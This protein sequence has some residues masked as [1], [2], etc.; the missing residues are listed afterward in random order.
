MS[1]KSNFNPGII[2]LSGVL[3]LGAVPSAFSQTSSQEKSTQPATTRSTTP[4]KQ[5]TQKDMGSKTDQMQK[6]MAASPDDIRKAQQA[7]KDKGMYDGAV[8]GTMNAQF[9]K[10]LTD[11][12]TQNK[13]QVTG[14]L[15]HQTMMKLGITPTK[16]TK[17]KKGNKQGAFQADPKVRQVQ[18]ALQ[19]RGI[20]PGPIDGIM[21]PQTKKAIADFQRLQ[22]LYVSGHLDPQTEAA[23]GI[24]TMQNKTG[25]ENKREKPAAPKP[26][27]TPYNQNQTPQYD[28]D[29]DHSNDIGQTN[30]NMGLGTASTVE[31]IKQVQIALKNRGYDP[32]DINGM[33][34]SQTQEAV[35]KFQAANNLPVT[36]ILD[37]RT[38]AALGVT[39]KGTS[40][41]D[42]FHAPMPDESTNMGP[43]S[44]TGTER[45]K[46]ESAANTGKMDS[47]LRERAM[48]AAD[49][50]TD[51]VRASDKRIPDALFQRAEAIAVIPN[52]IKG[53]FGIG[54]RYGKGLLSERTANGLWSAPTFITIGGG[55]FGAQLG[56]SSTDL[57][58]IF[59]DKDA[60][61]KFENGMSFKLGVDAGVVAGP[62]GRKGEAGVTGNLKSAVYSYSRSKG[63][64]A[65]IAL[66]GAVIDIDD[67]ANHSAYGK[68]ANASTI[69]SSTA[70]ASNVNVQPFMQALHRVAGKKTS[71]Q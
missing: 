51:A 13:L 26:E 37:D 4:E 65:G 16:G 48:K 35:R 53:A 54:G 70:M 68:T 34:S 44:P 31:D 50:L 12:Q 61:K 14:K 18:E 36:G 6:K 64:F 67:D 42:T 58:L 55:S 7:M 30:T 40:N 66:D 45:L 69:L 47:D 8:D 22:N 1:N 32:G 20:D 17:E 49:V 29:A 39:V 63:L 59:T 21:G 2:L 38:Q 9:E 11:Y 19:S 24:G 33:V 27:P 60:L 28:P 46:A 52:M 23:L 43:K 71:A 62:I 3:T 25:E 57:V 5:G 56:V 15:D 41:P 10:A